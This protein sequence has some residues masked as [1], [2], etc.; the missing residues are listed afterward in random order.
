[1][2]ERSVSPPE[3]ENRPGGLPPREVE[4]LHLAYGRAW[5]PACRCGCNHPPARPLSD[6]QSAVAADLWCKGWSVAEIARY[7]GVAPERVDAG[8]TR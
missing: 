6:A 1:M 4:L 2:W 7:L 5:S 8:G 3:P